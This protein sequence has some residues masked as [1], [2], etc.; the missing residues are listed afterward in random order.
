MKYRLEK[1]AMGTV[2]VPKDA[3]YGIQ[4]VRASKNF[5]ISGLRIHRELIQ[6]VVEIKRAAAEANMRVKVLNKKTGEAIVKA[7]KEI[8]KNGYDNEFIIDVY[9]AGAGTPWHMNV[10]EVVSNVALGY[11]GKK[12]GQYEYC[13][14]HDHVNRG[15]STNDV[16]PTA[17]RIASYEMIDSLEKEMK[18]LIL[19]LNIKGREFRDLAKTGRTHLQDAVPITLGMEFIAW[20]NAIQKRLSVLDLMKKNL[21]YIHLGGSAIGTGLNVHPRFTSYAVQYLKKNTKISWNSAHN[22]IEQT[23]FMSDFLDVSSALRSLAVDLGKICDDLRLLS[24]GPVTGLHE[25][26]LP[27]V[28]PGSSIMPGK[29]NP[30]MAEMMNMVCYQVIGN[31]STVQKCASAGELELNV[32]TPVMAYNLL[33]SLEILRSG[34]REFNHRCVKGIK[35]DKKKLKEY[36][37]KNAS[38]ATVL[39]NVLG[40]DK[41]AE[42]VKEAVKRHKSVKDIVIQKR[43][44]NQKEAEELFSLKNFRL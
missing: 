15:Q 29:F 42:V 12:K 43:L 25:I 19:V 7:C 8:L 21:R 11:L 22:K 39:N 16:I 32:M 34:I 1:D 44:L 31:D 5:R 41:A 35:A 2:N 14:P 36:F 24:S 4:T 20:A 18:D 27:K 38:I 17:L 26:E 37:E 23:Q 28:E 33:Q 6:A 9:Q 30:S 10:N 13:D 40:Y 3:Y